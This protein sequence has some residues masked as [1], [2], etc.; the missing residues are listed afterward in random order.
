VIAAPHRHASVRTSSLVA[1][2]VGAAVLA[3]PSTAQDLPFVGSEVGQGALLDAIGQR[4]PR[5]VRQVGTTSVTLRSDLGDGVETAFKPRTRTHPRGY[6]YE[7]AA[8]RIARALGM[9]N[10]PPAIGRS[11]PR[12]VME[13]RFEGRAPDE[14]ETLRANILWDAPGAARGAA[15]YW[16]PRMR[17][18]ELSTPAGLETALPWLAQTGEVPAG[19]AALA[20]DLSTMI[21]FDYLIANVDRFSGGNVS[22]DANGERLF[23]RDHNLAF[24]HPLSAERYERLR[25]LLARSTRFSRSFVVALS[26]LDEARL[27]AALAED[28]EGRER[29]LLSDAQIEG[30]LGR[31]RALL[32]YVAALVLMHGRERVLVWP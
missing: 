19:R 9:D 8:Y 28:P 2:L 18:T 29:P 21:A 23:V 12:L 7:I 17:S 32:S 20:R 10:V 6:A 11:M 25:A 24:I 4:L 26:E 30:V 3:S 13:Q 31:R 15:I 22:T 1:T 16:I 14:W 5:R 27:R